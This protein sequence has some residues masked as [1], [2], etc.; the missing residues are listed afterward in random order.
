MN[1]GIR[2]S[3]LFLHLLPGTLKIR[4]DCRTLLLNFGNLLTRR[5]EQ[6]ISFLLSEKV[7]WPFPR[8]RLSRRRNERPRERAKETMPKAKPHGCAWKVP[9][10]VSG[11]IKTTRPSANPDLFFV[12]DLWWTGHL[13]NLYGC[14]TGNTTDYNPG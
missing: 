12:S 6:T 14:Q 5:E 7:C 10:N 1:G 4:L 13:H 9:E 3:T 8:E 2:T 11:I